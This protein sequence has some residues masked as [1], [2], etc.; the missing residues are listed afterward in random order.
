[1]KIAV[2]VKQVYDTESKLVLSD[3]SIEVRNPK[4]IINPYDEFAIEEAI[5]AKEHYGCSAT[6][7]SIAPATTASASIRQ[8][9]AMGI[10]DAVLIDCDTNIPDSYMK[11]KILN[12]ALRKHG[13][14]DIIYLGTLS[15]DHNQSSTG[16]MLGAFFD[17]PTATNVS[18]ISYSET[19]AVEMDIGGGVKHKIKLGT[20]CII[21]T[22]KSL[23]LPRYPKLPNIIKAKQKPIEI[24]SLADLDIDLNESKVE[25]SNFIPPKKR[26][27]VHMIKGDIDRQASELVR[28]LKDEA[29]VL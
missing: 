7:F 3:N 17:I 14:F 11:T 23:N 27:K 16:P 6:L 12:L 26:N 29:K 1:M 15:I 18:K 22:T 10:D 21:T 24:L 13:S 28:F 2:C 20:P 25:F 19:I 8:A 9:L 5:K 4:W